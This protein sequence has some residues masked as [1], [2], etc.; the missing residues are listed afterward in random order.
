MAFSLHMRGTTTSSHVFFNVHGLTSSSLCAHTVT[1]LQNHSVVFLSETWLHSTQTELIQ[2]KTLI[3]VPATKPSGRGRPSGGLHLYFNPK[4][5]SKVNSSDSSHISVTFDHISVIGCYFRPQSD[6][7]DIVLTL[8]TALN[9]IPSTLPVIIGGD[10]NV[11]PDSNEFKEISQFL[12]SYNITLISDPK[13][14]TYTHSKGT[15]VIDYIFTSTSLPIRKVQTLLLT[16]SDHF[17]LQAIVKIRRKPSMS[18]KYTESKLD[19]N[20]VINQLNQLSTNIQP[21]ILCSNIDSI[22][23][24]STTRFTRKVNKTPW[25]S[26]V[27]YELRKNCQTLFKKSRSDPSYIQNYVIARKAYR[28]HLNHSK[29]NYERSKKD[30]M[31]QSAL[32]NGISSLYKSA[33]KQNE[34]TSIDIKELFRYSKDLYQAPNSNQSFNALPSCENRNHVLLQP[35]TK[36]EIESCIS[37]FKSKA[38]ST[39]SPLSPHS[40]KLISPSLIPLLQT[41]FNH[42]LST[43]NFPNS[44]S[45]SS[46]FFLHKKGLRSN[47][48]NYRSIAVE[49]PFLKTFMSLLNIRMTSFAE[50]ENLLPDYQFGFRSSRNCLSAAALLHEIASNQIKNKKKLYTAFIDFTKAFDKID[51]SILFQKLQILGFPTKI[52]KLLHSLLPNIKFQIRHNS[53]LSPKFYTEVGTPQGDPLSPLLFSLF[54][55]DLPISLPTSSISISN[56]QISSLL[57]A[58]DTAILANSAENLQIALNSLLNYCNTN[59]LN[60]NIQ[61]SKILIFHRGRLTQ[62]ILFYNNE[63]L[64][65]VKEF[66]YLGITFSPQLSFTKHLSNM[67][68]IAN[69]KIGFLFHSLQLKNLNLSTILQIFFCF[70]WPIFTYGCHI[71]LS[72]YSNSIANTLNSVFTKYLKR[73]LCIPKFSNNSITHFIT[74]T[75]PLMDHIKQFAY[76]HQFSAGF[77]SSLS[78]LQFSFIRSIPNPPPQ[79]AIIPLIPSTFWISPVISHLPISPSFRHHLLMPIF[80]P[81]FYSSRDSRNE[82]VYFSSHHHLQRKK[83]F[84]KKSGKFLFFL[85]NIHI[86]KN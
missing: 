27:S 67:I 5:N 81:F 32:Q 46:F 47:P 3:S 15:S 38:S 68:A 35:F 28:S 8:A 75:L 51:R 29:R 62:P 53:L 42:A 74:N 17:P 65:I 54:I 60:V 1:E 33:K 21:E 40:L 22:L 14:P 44:W 55:S 43:S 70:I 10:F 6:L 11:H 49:N 20:S 26:S 48:S 78:G 83:F 61:K 69:S 31:I 25:F 4:F 50:T 86:H 34:N 30:L 45:E 66:K 52:C 79:D 64:E 18:T 76:S 37:K 59:H 56:V 77:P 82:D 39:S 7:D 80:T 24:N 13:T 72:S 85:A 23:T 58:D 9:N 57:Y 36:E 63:P 41:I 16:S 73:Y 84:I 71:W 2:S 12:R 19:F